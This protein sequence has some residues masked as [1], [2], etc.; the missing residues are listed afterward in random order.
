MHPILLT[1]NSP[2]NRHSLAGLQPDTNYKVSIKAKNLKAA[3]TIMSGH[4][5]QQ[6]S[7]SIEL[8]TEPQGLPEPPVDV[9]G[10]NSIEYI[11]A[12]VLA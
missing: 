6:L 12:R 2:H 1:R 10:G 4:N 5:L 9:Q 8:R 11:L 7:S 3:S